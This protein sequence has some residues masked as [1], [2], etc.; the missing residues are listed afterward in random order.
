MSILRLFVLCRSLVY[1]NFNC[2]FSLDFYTEKELSH[3]PVLGC[4]Q[5]EKVEV[6]DNDDF[7]LR[8][9]AIDQFPA[10]DFNLN[11]AGWPR[12]V[13]SELSHAQSKAEYDMILSR[14]QEL[15]GNYNIPDDMDTDTAIS[16]IKPRSYQ[17]ACDFEKFAEKAADYDM[18]LYEKFVAAKQQAADSGSEPASSPS[19]E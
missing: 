4:S 18:S 8:A 14:I 17:S 5:V 7:V 15:R 12:N 1:L 19:N 3:F 9:V 10:Q 11:D 2:M 13:I 6:S 16:L